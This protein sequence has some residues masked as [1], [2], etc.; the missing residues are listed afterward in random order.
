MQGPSYIS[1][2]VL[3]SHHKNSL[4][5]SSHINQSPSR[6]WLR[7]DQRQRSGRPGESDGLG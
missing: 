4:Q 2:H 3:L 5:R 1:I 7:L 6:F